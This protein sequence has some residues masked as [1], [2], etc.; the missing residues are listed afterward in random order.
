MCEHCLRGYGPL[1]NVIVFCDGC[2]RCWHQ[3]CHDPIIPRKLVLD[4]STEWFCNECSAI[5]EK[6]ERVKRVA[7]AQKI[8]KTT[9]KTEKPVTSTTLPIPAEQARLNYWKSLSKEDLIEILVMQSSAIALNPSSQVSNSP[10]QLQLPA[11]QPHQPTTAAT[12][13][14]PTSTAPPAPSTKNT[15]TASYPT[16]NRDLSDLDPE[17]QDDE[18]QLAGDEY[19]DDYDDLLDEHARLYPK[20]GNGVQLPPESEDLG[21]L[22]EGGPEAGSGNRGTFSHQLFT[23][24]E[25]QVDAAAKVDI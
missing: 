21:M 6:A 24:G 12:G 20:P 13:P 2:N 14:P 11:P 23:A 25:G 16:P 22:L 18:Q 17:A 5:K 1:K 15:L 9:T 7:P 8:A 19:D 10:S 3:K 4:P